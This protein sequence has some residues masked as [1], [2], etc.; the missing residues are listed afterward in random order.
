[1]VEVNENVC[2]IRVSTAACSG[3]RLRP[4]VVGFH[5][6]V[7]SCGLARQSAAC[8]VTLIK[9]QRSMNGSI[10]VAKVQPHQRLLAPYVTR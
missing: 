10:A 6:D 3:Y 5:R 4:V 2:N 7:I 9:K 1:M 8:N